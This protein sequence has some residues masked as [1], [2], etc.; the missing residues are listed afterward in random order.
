MG[1]VLLAGG[2]D[3]RTGCSARHQH[4]FSSSSSS[5]PFFN[6]KPLLF[7]QILTMINHW[8]VQSDRPP[9]DST[10]PT[11]FES[12]PFLLS[13]FRLTSSGCSDSPTPKVAGAI[14]KLRRLCST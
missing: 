10:S 9:W 8:S 5:E 6:P 13:S 14:Q 2:Q 7:Q 1:S 3:R 11:S 4:F 12:L